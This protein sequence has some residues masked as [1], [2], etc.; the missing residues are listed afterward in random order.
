[1]TDGSLVLV[2]DDGYAE[3]YERVRPVLDDRGVPACLSIVPD[4]IGREGHLSADELSDLVGSGWEIAAHGRRHRYLQAHG[5]ARDA[6]AGDARVFLDSDH[7]FPGEDHGIYPGDDFEITDG[8]AKE[9]RELAGKG[10]EGDPYV[11]FARPLNDDY[12]ADEAVLRPT[13]S[14]LDDEIV[15]VREAFRDLGHDPS[16]FVLPYDAGDARAWSLIEDHYEALADA[17]VRSLP[18]PPGTSL[19]NLRRYY[20]ETDAMTMVDIETYLD[21]VAEQGGIGVLAGHAAW[22]TVPPE[23]VAA[24]VDAALDCGIE[25]TTFEDLRMR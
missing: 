23:R 25:V 10:K 13:P 15:G 18:N 19:T 22:E 14:L 24:V 20:L 17:A 8:E 1:M 4:W 6:G 2:F 11:D 16:T 21:R 5:L 7:V 12:A 9:V 3:D